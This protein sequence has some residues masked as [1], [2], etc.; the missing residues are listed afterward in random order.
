[1]TPKAGDKNIKYNDDKGRKAE[2]RLIEIREREVDELN[3]VKQGINS[4]DC[5]WNIIQNVKKVA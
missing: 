5:K 3:Y 4:K 1:M 2:I